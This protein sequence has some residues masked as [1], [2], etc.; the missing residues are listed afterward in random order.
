MK[1][2]ISITMVYLRFFT[3]LLV[4]SFCDGIW[5][6]NWKKERKKKKE[7]ETQKKKKKEM[8]TCY[9]QSDT[10]NTKLVLWCTFLLCDVLLQIHFGMEFQV[11]SWSFLYIMCKMYNLFFVTLLERCWCLVTTLLRRTPYLKEGNIHWVQSVLFIRWFLPNISSFLNTV[12]MV[13]YSTYLLKKQHCVL[14]DALS[15]LPG[16]RE[17][18][19]RL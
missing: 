14:Q 4:Q 3:D 15:I 7:I 13:T 8:Y 10:V 19:I 16:Y 5:L 9:M 6:G 18:C 11:K 1:L 12:L 2:P 17:Y